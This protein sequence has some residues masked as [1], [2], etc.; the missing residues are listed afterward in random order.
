MYLHMKEKH[1]DYY[2]DEWKISE[3]ELKAV[4]N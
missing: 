4:K 2:S 3:E 1:G